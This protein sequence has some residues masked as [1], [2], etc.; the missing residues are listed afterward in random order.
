MKSKTILFI[1]LIISFSVI[2]TQQKL[3]FSAEIAESYTQNNVKVKIFKNNVKIIDDNKILYTDLAEY[4]QDSSKV[5]LNGSVKMYDNTDSLICNKLILVKGNNERYEA[6]GDVVFYQKNHIIQAEHLIYYT[7]D[8]KIIAFDNVLLQDENKQIYGDSLIVNY[9]NNL[10]SDLIM[11]DNIQLFNQKKYFLKDNS[12]FQI[13]EDKM[14]SNTLL[15]KFNSNEN[16]NNI[17]LLGMAK[18]NL[19]IVNDSLLNGLN[20]VSGDT[21]FIQFADDSIS[22]MD[23]NGGVVGIFKPDPQNKKLNNNISYNAQSVTYNLI[24]EITLLDGNAIINYGQTILEGGEIETDL[25]NSI[26][27]SNIKNTVL[28]SVQ[29]ETQPPTYGDYMEFDLITETGNI[30]NGYNQIDMGIFKGDNFFTNKN[31]DVYIDYGMFTSCDHPNPHYYFGSNKMKVDNSS[32][33]IIAKPMTLYIQDLP[34][35]S[36]PF[37]ILP[38]SNE[39]RKSGFMMPAFGHNENTGTWIQDLGYYYAPND[40]YDITT[41]LDF[42]DRSRVQIDSR[43][44]YKKSSGNYWY[45]YKFSGFIQ[46]KNYVNQLIE[47]NQDFTDLSTNATKQYSTIFEHIQDFSNNQ[48]I[49]IK[50]E[51]YGFENLSEI[52]ENDISIRLDQQEISQLFYSRTWDY[53]TLTIGGASI[54]DLILPS[55]IYEG[56][57]RTYKNIEYP[58]IKYRYNKPLL[59]G[60]GDRWYNST[61]FGYNFSAYNKDITYAKESIWY[62]EGENNGCTN[63]GVSNSGNYDDCTNETN[64]SPN[65][66][67]GINLDNSELVWSDIGITQQI[68]PSAEHNIFV[69]MPIS[70]FALNINPSLSL[71]EHWVISDIFGNEDF[72][73]IA[74]KLKGTFGVNIQTS[75]YGIIPNKIF[76]QSIKTIRH[77]MTPSFN[78]NYIS[79]SKLLKGSLNDFENTYFPIGENSNN[80]SNLVSS[81][82]IN[83]LFQAKILN[84]N[85]EFLKRDIM[86]YNLSTSYNWDN[87]LFNALISTI[88]LKNLSGGE[89]LRIDLEQSLYEEGTTDLLNGLPRLTAVKTSVSRTFGYELIGENVN[90]LE[91]D[92]QYA[93]STDY[94]NQDIWDATFGFTLTAKY[95]LINKW[96][97]EYSTLSVNSNVNLSK[98]WKMNNKMYI[99]LVDMKINSYELEFTRSLHCWDFAFMMKTIGYNKGFGLKISI[100]DPNLQSIKVT[101]S[102]MKRGNNW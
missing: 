52:I 96:N 56:E 12:Q 68:K 63:E 37:A 98:E 62:S 53:S 47:P 11:I 94:L 80:I 81:I 3:N 42:Y 13:L 60:D 83:N 102:T 70:L 58:V 50:Y 64:N 34:T 26:V 55:P 88:S 57:I 66:S 30:T 69:N 10:I 35:F 87:K 36:V 100:S 9:N 33:Q 65:T 2:F 39:E 92:N 6:S 101:Q 27:K 23:I 48:Y 17:Q 99:D 41:Y 61:K 19:H 46:L 22:R 51:Y 76:N 59:F 79:K 5:I 20:S 74:R 29:T 91:N 90:D 21:I 72:N 71:S 97:L 44:N 4:F 15:I 84:K 54:R 25:K 16:I 49:R 8:D 89:Y 95:D 24:D 43:L 40:Y 85:G 7:I 77:I 67:Q 1:I 78:T 45:N 38:N 86:A 75:L 32:G 73:V 93:N 18:A 14:E 28:P 31:E 82:S